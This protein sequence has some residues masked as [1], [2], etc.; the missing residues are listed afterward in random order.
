MA[1]TT[2][3][4]AGLP[5]P[6]KKESN[7]EKRRGF[8]LKTVIFMM[9]L[10]AAAAYYLAVTKMERTWVSTVEGIGTVAVDHTRAAGAAADIEKKALSD[11]LQRIL[12]EDAV[13]RMREK[14]Q[15]LLPKDDP[16][17]LD[18]VMFW[19]EG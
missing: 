13:K 16:N 8:S 17:L 14:G 5:Y 4:P 18:T 15:E 9:V 11:A 19:R 10:A 3:E 1:G 12:A 2:N 7:M 6:N